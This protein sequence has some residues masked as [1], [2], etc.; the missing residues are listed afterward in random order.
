MNGWCGFNGLVVGNTKI[1]LGTSSNLPGPEPP[2][3]SGMIATWWLES[4]INL[5]Y[6]RL[7]SMSGKC[8]LPL[9]ANL[10]WSHI[11]IPPIPMIMG[12]YHLKIRSVANQDFDKICTSTTPFELFLFKKRRTCLWIGR[13]SVVW[14]YLQPTKKSF[15]EEARTRWP[16]HWIV[17]NIWPQKC[18][19]LCWNLAPKWWIPEVWSMDLNELFL[20]KMRFVSTNSV[21]F[22]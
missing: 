19:K 4:R 12:G 13:S 5:D 20:Y 2:G 8:V 11:P 6:W 16:C 22:L 10:G 7:H 15:P 18:W 14:P 3:M 21:F 17:E 9:K 1:C